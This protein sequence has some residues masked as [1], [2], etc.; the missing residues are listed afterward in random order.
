MFQALGPALDQLFRSK[1]KDKEEDKKAPS[2]KL[3]MPE[4]EVTV[5]AEMEAPKKALERMRKRK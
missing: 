2:R 1:K 3:D 4:V 5:E